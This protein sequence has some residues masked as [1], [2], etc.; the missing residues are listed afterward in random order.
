[1]MSMMKK[2]REAERNKNLE[3]QFV[4]K[5]A[6]RN[7]RI[8]AEQMVQIF[9]DNEVQGMFYILIQGHR[10]REARQVPGLTIIW[11]P[12]NIYTLNSFCLL[13]CSKER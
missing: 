3:A 13:D 9:K 1:M 6:N 7:G 4:K 2:R 5:D 10:N 8:N 11:Q 12:K